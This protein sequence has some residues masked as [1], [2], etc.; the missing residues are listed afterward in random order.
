MSKLTSRP[1]QQPEEVPYIIS[2]SNRENSQTLILPS[3][4][5]WIGRLSQVSPEGRGWGKPGSPC[6]PRHS[7][8]RTVGQREREVSVSFIVARLPGYRVPVG[9]PSHI[10]ARRDNVKEQGQVEGIIQL[11][12][13]RIGR[14][15]FPRTRPDPVASE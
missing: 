2:L 9:I 6:H 14:L 5:G 15:Q 3:F 4:T 13:L 7:H 10:S 8:C 1:A 11:A 12:S